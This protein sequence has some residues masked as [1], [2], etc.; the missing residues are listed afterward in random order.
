MS[1]QTSLIFQR[2]VDNL[3]GVDFTHDFLARK[4]CLTIL[5]LCHG[6]YWVVFMYFSEIAEDRKL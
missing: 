5:S 3:E 2:M 1:I 4:S 6:D